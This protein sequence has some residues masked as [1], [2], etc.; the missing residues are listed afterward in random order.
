MQYTCDS[1]D[2]RREIFGQLQEKK[3]SY[4]S[5]LTLSGKVIAFS[6]GEDALKEEEHLIWKDSFAREI[7]MRET[8]MGYSTP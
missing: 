8:D 1:Y 2:L 3:K 5:I 7:L 4:F 6:N